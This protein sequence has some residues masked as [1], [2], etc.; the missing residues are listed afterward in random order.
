M[1]LQD[2]KRKLEYAIKCLFKTQEDIFEY[3]SESVFTEW[4]L[5]H[6]LAFEIQKLFPDHQHD[7]ELIKPN[8]KNK[9]PDIILHKRNTNTE[10]YLV[11]ELKYRNPSED[12]LE[13]I[14]EYWFNKRLNYKFGATIMID[15]MNEYQVDVVR[16]PL[17]HEKSDL[18]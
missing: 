2:I 13:K 14:K 18:K 8:L 4:N 3:T 10:N 5:A 15:N 7:V 9:R 12:D 16:N 17:Y 11:I 6:H 1:E